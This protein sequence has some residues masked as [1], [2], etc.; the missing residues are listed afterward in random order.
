[1]QAIET[2]FAP[3]G[4][5]FLEGADMRRC[6]EAAGSLDDW[7]SFAA[8]W[9]A[10]EVDEYVAS[11]G[12]SRRRRFGVFAARADGAVEAQPH[13]AH[14]QHE[15][16][17]ALFGGIERW[18]APLAPAVASS[19]SLA[20]ILEFCRRTFGAL[21]PDVGEW[22]I[23]V[24]QFRIEPVAG[25]PGEPTPE[26][27]HRDGVDFV[28]VLL[29]DR[30]NIE[31]GTTTVV[32]PGGRTLGSFTLTRPFDA[33]LL[34]DRRVAHGV[35]PVTAVDPAGP[36]HRDVLVVTLRAGGDRHRG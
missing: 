12:R 18:F 21:R 28:L 16:Y 13:Q 30:V 32:E 33:A 8:S 15:D 34:D 36:A 22:R 10:L 35:T 29:V 3:A 2:A 11:R 25:A 24:H 27:M 26:G 20:T 17:N 19:A 1:M 31:S 7:R 23:E 14:Y 6:L 4:F 9:S 5:M